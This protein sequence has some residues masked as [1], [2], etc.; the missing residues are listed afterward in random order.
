MSTWTV[1]LIGPG[2]KMTGTVEADERFQVERLFADDV[3]ESAALV[4]SNIVVA[5]EGRREEL[6]EFL[7]LS[8]KVF[9]DDAFDLADSLI[10]KGWIA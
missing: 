5:P 1:M 4:V 9:S 6:G 10:E 8:H 2:I 7:I 3:T